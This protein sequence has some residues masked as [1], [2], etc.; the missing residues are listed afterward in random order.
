MLCVHCPGDASHSG[1]NTWVGA[2]DLDPGPS[3]PRT[4]GSPS[5]LRCTRGIRPARPSSRVRAAPAPAPGE[6][7]QAR[8]APPG[9]RTRHLRHRT[10]TPLRPRLSTPLPGRPGLG[11]SGCPLT[12][13]ASTCPGRRAWFRRPAFPPPPPSSRAAR[14]PVQ[15][16]SEGG[17]SGERPAE[18]PP[19]LRQGCGF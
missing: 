17:T 16:Y 12:G 9:E 2:G 15:Q 1:V 10:P 7:E 14:F 8:A 13:F 4:E 18:L 11:T 19:G 3:C 6:G 5:H